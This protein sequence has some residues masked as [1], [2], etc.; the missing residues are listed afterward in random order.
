MVRKF[1]TTN[2]P[3]VLPTAT[4]LTA[5]RCEGLGSM[6]TWTLPRSRLAVRWDNTSPAPLWEG[7]NSGSPF[8]FLN[9]M[10]GGRP[11]TPVR[12]FSRPLCAFTAQLNNVGKYLLLPQ[13]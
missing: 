13:Q 8:I 4:G 11:S 6:V 1:I 5:S 12:M 9:K 7:G 10:T 2:S 3:L